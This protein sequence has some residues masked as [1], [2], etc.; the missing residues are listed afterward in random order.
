VCKSDSMLSILVMV[1]TG[2][3]QRQTSGFLKTARTLLMKSKKGRLKRSSLEARLC[4]AL[5]LSQQKVSKC[6]QKRID[7][8]KLVQTEQWIA[9]NCRA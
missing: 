6:L 5:E 7:A 1:A 2:G 9:I 4:R 3:N 8:N